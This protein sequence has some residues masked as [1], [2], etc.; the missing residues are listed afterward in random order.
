MGYRTIIA[1]YVAKWGIA[2]MCQCETKYQ[3]G[4]ASFWGSANLTAGFLYRAGAKTPEIFE[5]IKKSFSQ[6][7]FGN[8]LRGGYPN[9]SS[10]IHR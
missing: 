4:I 9:R 2:Q 1:Q 5:K 6:N 10:G 8:F 7:D 3:G